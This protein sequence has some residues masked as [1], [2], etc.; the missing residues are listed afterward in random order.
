MAARAARAAVVSA[1]MALSSI[2]LLERHI[3]T[4][5]APTEIGDIQWKL[6]ERSGWWARP[7]KDRVAF[8]GA[9]PFVIIHHSYKPGVAQSE[10]DCRLAMQQIQ[11]LHMEERHWSDIGYS[12]AICGDGNVYVGRGA[13]VVAAHAPRYNN[14]SIGLL[15]IGEELPPS[16]MMKVALDFIQFSVDYGFL[17]E[18]YI[19][20]G[21]RQVRNGTICPGDA[22]YTELQKWPH[23]QENV[24]DIA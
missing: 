4:F 16:R 10:S 3:T 1:L 8:A 23:W 17:R 9:A 13:N 2:C 12:Y 11:D 18:D 14:R 7:P 6:I 19:L 24:N 21:H 15:L 20:Y 22:L 5:A